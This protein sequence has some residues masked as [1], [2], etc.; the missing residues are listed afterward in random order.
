[1]AVNLGDSEHWAKDYL[2]QV[3]RHLPGRYEIDMSSDP[4]PISPTLLFSSDV[5]LYFI[6][7]RASTRALAVIAS[8]EFEEAETS[9]LGV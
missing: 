1:M 6:T 9:R 4:H 2:G 5:W 8:P 3:D 7:M